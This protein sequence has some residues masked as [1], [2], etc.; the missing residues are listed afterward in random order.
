MKE[1]EVITITLGLWMFPAILTLAGFAQLLWPSRDRDAFFAPI[2]AGIWAAAVI[3]A[4][5]FWGLTWLA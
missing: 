4:W 1:I 2:A 3:T 5:A